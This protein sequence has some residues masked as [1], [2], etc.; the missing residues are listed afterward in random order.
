M[1]RKRN[2]TPNIS[3]SISLYIHIWTCLYIHCCCDGFCKG[4]NTC[5]LNLISGIKN[6]ST[7][8]VRIGSQPLWLCIRFDI[9]IY[10]Y[11]CRPLV[12]HQAA[13]V[14]ASSVLCMSMDHS[15]LDTFSVYQF[16]GTWYLPDSYRYSP[17]IIFH[18]QLW[19]NV[20]SHGLPIWHPG[21]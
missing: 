13:N 16:S 3:L 17:G 6:Q 20:G 1:Q 12:G 4:L 5:I 2:R 7:P 14:F 18:L 21:F 10:I 19:G 11:I 8:S 9:Y 15:L